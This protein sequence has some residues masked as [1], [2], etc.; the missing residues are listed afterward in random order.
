MS[1]SSSSSDDSDSTSFTCSNPEVVKSYK[2][3][4]KQ[5]KEYA[6]RLCKPRPNV[7]TSTGATPSGA[8]SSSGVASSNGSSGA[9]SSSAALPKSSPV[10][11]PSAAA[12]A[13]PR[14]EPAAKSEP[15]VAVVKPTPNAG[16]WVHSTKKVE[17]NSKPHVKKGHGKLNQIASIWLVH[18]GSARRWWASP[19]SFAQVLVAEGAWGKEAETSW[20]TFLSLSF[21]GVSW[22]LIFWSI[23]TIII[24]LCWLLLLISFI[25]IWIVLSPG[26]KP[27]STSSSAISPKI[28]TKLQAL[29]D[30]CF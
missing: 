15:A 23:Q 19:Q 26:L 11:K 1:S 28:S 3:G 14:E 10:E 25:L 8:A 22:S 13:T 30:R 4:C 21:L 16:S 9:A 5:E 29:K 7:A 27:R 24:P 20:D 2:K 17:L 12:P 18:W 6:E